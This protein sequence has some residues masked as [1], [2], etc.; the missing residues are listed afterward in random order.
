MYPLDALDAVGTS[1]PV[2]L[3]HHDRPALIAR[4]NRNL[5]GWRAVRKRRQ[6]LPKNPDQVG[7]RNSFLGQQ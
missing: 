2:V 4:H 5:D 3:G 1:V 6:L 7:A